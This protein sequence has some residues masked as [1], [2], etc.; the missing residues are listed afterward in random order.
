MISDLHAITLR[1]FERA[2]PFMPLKLI[3]PFTS[4][5]SYLGGRIQHDSEK[6]QTLS[7]ITYDLATLRKLDE[8]F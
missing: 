8:L 6:H 2:M 7:I 4:L 1:S 5:K 3:Y